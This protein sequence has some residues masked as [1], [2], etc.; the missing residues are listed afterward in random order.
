MIAGE[1]GNGGMTEERWG[2]VAEA[3]TEIEP[4]GAR[5]QTATEASELWRTAYRLGATE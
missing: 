5:P 2:A 3:C 1:G 4:D